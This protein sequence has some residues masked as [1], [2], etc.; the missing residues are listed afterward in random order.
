MSLESAKIVGDV[1]DGLKDSDVSLKIKYGINLVSNG[2]TIAPKYT[3]EA[4]LVY[5]S[6]ADPM[7]LYTLIC[8]DPDPP[9]PEKPIYKEW[10]HWIVI[11]IPGRDG[12]ASAGQ[13]ITRYM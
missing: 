5:F 11:N 4:P 9:D 7:A 8:T 10:L 2:A 3:T 6:G 13:E 1:I 12:D